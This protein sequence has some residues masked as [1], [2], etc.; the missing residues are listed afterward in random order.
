MCEANTNTRNKQPPNSHQ[1]AIHRQKKQKGE[2]KNTHT[3]KEN[4]NRHTKFNV[5]MN[6]DLKE[7]N[8][9]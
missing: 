9:R 4:K 8:R 2:I 5:E 6:D 1:T 3:K 7:K